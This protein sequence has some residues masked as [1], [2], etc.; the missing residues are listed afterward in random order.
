MEFRVDGVIEFHPGNKYRLKETLNFVSPSGARVALSSSRD[1]DLSVQMTLKAENVEEAKSIAV[2][3][4]DRIANLL[5]YYRNVPIKGDRTTGVAYEQ[6]D[7][8]GKP[9]MIME[10]VI[11]F[12]NEAST[13]IEL[14]RKS[15]EKLGRLFEKEYPPDFHDVI[16]MYRQ[17]VSIEEPALEYVLL[18]RLMEF[19][20]KNDTKT[21]TGWIKKKEPSVTIHPSDKYRNYDYT[22][23]T[24]LRDNIHAKAKL[25]PHTEIGNVLSKFQNLVKKALEEEFEARPA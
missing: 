1:D 22:H 3:E 19:L 9:T 16:S 12:H 24:Y 7:D 14:G 25:F 21:L 18:Y 13:V 17:A 20:F 6:L 10:E 8:E 11:R 5:S 23:Y 4:L 2:I 15:G